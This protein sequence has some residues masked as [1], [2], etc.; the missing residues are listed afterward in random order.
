MK[1]YLIM[2]IFIYL[3]GCAASGYGENIVYG[4]IKTGIESTKRF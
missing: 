1:K 3:T 4:E 2:S